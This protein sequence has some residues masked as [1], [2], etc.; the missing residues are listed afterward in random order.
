MSELKLN[1]KIA[2]VTGAGR[3]IGRAIAEA[4]A[5]EGAKVVLTARTREQIEEAAA[6]IRAAGGEALA[7]AADAT[8]LEEIQEVFRLAAETFGGVDIVVANAGGNY[9]RKRIEEGDPMAWVATV[10]LNLNTAYYTLYAAIPYLKRRGGGKVIMMGSGMGR[11]GAKGNS[12]YAVAKAGM[13]MLTRVAAQEL[14]EHNIAVNE[15]SPGPVR[16]E[17]TRGIE[18]RARSTG[19]ETVFTNPVEWIKQPEDVA[20]LAV[21]LAAMPEPG[22]SAQSFCLNRRDI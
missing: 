2:V 15:I 3:G 4:Y 7:V 14:A 11:R 16:T 13:W 12:S 19:G 21:F 6:A 20:P 5:R 22:P 10:E 18:E 8:K 1:N 9:D 17:L